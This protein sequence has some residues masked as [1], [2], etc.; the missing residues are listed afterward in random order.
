MGE[1]SIE[2]DELKKLIKVAKQRPLAF[3]V[4]PGKTDEDFLFSL[5]RKRSA[6]VLGKGLKKEGTGDKYAFGLCAVEGKVM[7]L[8]CERELPNLAKRLKKWLKSQKAPHNVKILDANGNVIDEDIE[9]L[10]DEA[11]DDAADDNVELFEDY[12]D[13]VDP[14]VAELRKKFLA[15]V[16]MVRALD[17][18]AK[19]KLQ[20]AVKLGL[21]KINDSDLDA[22]GKLLSHI[23][24]ELKKAPKAS[25]EEPS[26]DL[27][28]LAE[29][30]KSLRAGC[31]EAPPPANNT[32]L[33]A[34]ELAAAKLK[35][36]DAAAATKIIEKITSELSKSPQLDPLQVKWEQTWETLSPKLLAALN[37]DVPDAQKLRAAMTLADET[38]AG[39]DYKKALLIADRLEVRLKEALQ[40]KDAQTEERTER[41]ASVDFTKTRLMWVEARKTL[42]A[43]MDRVADA[44]V[45]ACTGDDFTG[46][47]EA[48]KGLYTYLDPLDEKLNDALDDLINDEDASSRE[49]KKKTCLSVI[50]SYQQVLSTGF[51]NDIDNK[52]GF[53]S[54]VKVQQTAV[55]ALDKIAKDLTTADPV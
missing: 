45:K 20:A 47:Q 33:K 27:R 53:V 8:T 52:N 26:E 17:G 37:A 1:L 12:G 32:L 5:H 40:A 3:A 46:M 11:E 35:A 22:A 31:L 54:G 21:E 7:T 49:T 25:A 13:A 10:G 38:A 51:F 30:L 19:P 50:E 4:V 28:A 44:I 6:D 9:D 36:K 48:V 42:K 23:L 41:V 34:W 2:G 14:K 16:P 24:A 43:E 15:V 18:E 39:G 29:K 55:S